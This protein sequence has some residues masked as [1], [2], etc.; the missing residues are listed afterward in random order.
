V[1]GSPYNDT[2]IAGKSNAILVGDAGA[3]HLIANS[4]TPGNDILIGGRTDYDYFVPGASGLLPNTAAK[5]G[6]FNALASVWQNT[7][8]ANYGGQVVLLRDTGISSNG[9]TYKLN[10]SSVHD[11]GHA[12]DTLTGATLSQA[13]LDW[14]F[15]NLG[16]DIIQNL[17]SPEITTLIT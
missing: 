1:I 6:A 7:T 11:D 10:S 14:I 15:E 3:D 16:T 13:A 12:V 8:T 17:K 9:V 5:I 4:G 2:L